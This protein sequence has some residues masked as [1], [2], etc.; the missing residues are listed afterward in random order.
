MGA[1]VMVRVE[2][3]PE[4]RL[5]GSG[6][7]AVAARAFG[8]VPPPALVLLGVVSVQVG[9]AVAKQLFPL[10]GSAGTVTLRL[11]LAAAVLLVVWRPSFRLD[12]RTLLVVAG[13]G[14][15]LGTMNLTFYQ[16]IERIPLGAAVTIEFLGPLAVAVLGS[17]RWVDGLWALLAALG[18][19]LLTRADGGLELTGVLFALAAAACW[20]AY[21]LLAAAL[22][23]RTSDGKG[24]A[25]AMV[26]GSALVLPFGMADA[27]TAL[28]DPVVLIAGAAVAL[29]SSV[30]PYSLELEALRRIPPRVFGI[31]MSLE[32]AVAA[33][34]GL[35]VLHEA[36]RPSQWVAVC[37]VV[38]ASVGATRSARPEP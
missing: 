1:V 9:A 38:L 17:R 5:P 4:R 2:G 12:R 8:A 35:V 21:I 33:F 34:A 6:V 25:L 15:V 26:F 29:L 23:S 10:V 16:A 31:L 14:A 28:L 3:L 37:C 7:P 19:V 32:P 18:V 13:Y 30:I 11:V 24:L 36:L 27:G 20:A 22:G